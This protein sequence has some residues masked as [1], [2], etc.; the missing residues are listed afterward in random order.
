MTGKS[1]AAAAQQTPEANEKPERTTVRIT[2]PQAIRALAHRVR[3]D[4]IDELFGSERTY[5]A[6]ELA[7]KFGLTPSAMSYHLRALER[8][9]YV[10]R[11]P[12]SVDARERHWK[13]AG[14]SLNVGDKSSAS[15]LVGS[16]LIDLQLTALRERILASLNAA[17]AAESDAEGLM[18]LATS[19]LR[20]TDA[21]VRAFQSEYHSMLERY[22]RI[23]HSDPPTELLEIH[24]TTAVVPD[25]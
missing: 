15:A 21:Q 3:L 2:D 12:S 10:L 24:V 4:V 1:D 13:A 23:E 6:T 20:L 11:A 25:T 16:T 9:G 18:M 7:K 5:T 19:K 17:E 14:D 22:R 8:W